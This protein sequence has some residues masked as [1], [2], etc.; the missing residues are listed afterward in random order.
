MDD[1]LYKKVNNLKDLLDGKYKERDILLKEGNIEYFDILD[2]EIEKMELEIKELEKKLEKLKI[3]TNYKTQLCRFYKKYGK[4]DKG[5][6]CFYAHGLKELRNNKKE[7]IN[8]SKCYDEI[9]LFKHPI[10]WNPYNNKT[11]CLKC[12]KGFCN[13]INKKYIHTNNSKFKFIVNKIILINR[14]IK[15]L[16]KN[17]YKNEKKLNTFINSNSNKPEINIIINDNSNKTT[18][19][20]KQDIKKTL[21][22]ME[23]DLEL[24]SEKIIN[25]FNNINLDD[26]LKINMKIQLNNIKSSVILLR[27]NLEDLENII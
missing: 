24:Y 17:K 14:I 6:K 11:E 10:D 12:K 18:N 1:K 2:K 22:M 7:C 21:Y 5:N 20:Y 16:E 19:E 13:K 27:H 9:C 25:N 4:C 8:Q 3:N 26:Y 15:F 23:K